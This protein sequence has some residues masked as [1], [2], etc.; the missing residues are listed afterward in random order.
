MNDQHQK[1]KYC[2][3]QGT[4][5]LMTATVS[6]KEGYLGQSCN[7]SNQNNSIVVLGD[8]FSGVNGN[9]DNP[10]CKDWVNDSCASWSNKCIIQ[11]GGLITNIEK[12]L[13]L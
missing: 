10:L 7:S 1:S 2:H 4:F 3:H 11:P 12:V 13:C 9:N 8:S 6:F 5:L